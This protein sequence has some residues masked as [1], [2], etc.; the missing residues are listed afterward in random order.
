MKTKKIRALFMGVALGLVCTATQAV[1]SDAEF[2]L[3]GTTLTPWGAEKAGSPDGSYPAYTGDLKAPAGFDQESGVW[4]DPYPDEKP[5]FVITA[6]NLA[7]YSD[8]LSD[9]QKALFKLYPATFN[10]FI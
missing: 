6:A 3:L 7:Q 5:L 8:Y 1:V 10:K 4:P 9:G 2:K